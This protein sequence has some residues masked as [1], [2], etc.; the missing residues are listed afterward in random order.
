MTNWTPDIETLC[1]DILARPAKGRRR[2]VALAGPPASG[3]STLAEAVVT[4]LKD[5]GQTAALVPMDGFH[6]DNRLLEPMG[7]LPRKGAP[8]TFD[9]L[10]FVRLVQALATEDHVAYPVFDRARDCAIAGA[11][12]VGPD[13]QTVVVEGNYLLLDRQPWSTLH[14]FWDVSMMLSVPMDELRRRL[15][16][17]WLHYGLAENDAVARAQGNDLPNAKVV[18]AGSRAELI[19]KSA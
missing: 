16:A 7:L 18:L 19:V 14:P 8:E 15:I 17:R 5:T 6:L 11:G 9:A 13:V 12:M 10:G 1:D 2:L 3:K 4:A